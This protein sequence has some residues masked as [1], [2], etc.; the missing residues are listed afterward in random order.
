MAESW[1]TQFNK[2]L[3]VC[4]SLKVRNS[5]TGSLR[6]MRIAVRSNLRGLSVMEFQSQGLS[7]WKSQ[8]DANSGS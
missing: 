4:L 1:F 8:Y 5:P 6:T 3:G 7:D 2:E